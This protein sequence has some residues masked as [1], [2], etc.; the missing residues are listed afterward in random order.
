[1]KTET[2]KTVYFAHKF[3]PDKNP[4]GRKDAVLWGF[5]PSLHVCRLAYGKDRTYHKVEVT[6]FEGPVDLAAYWAWQCNEDNKFK[7]VHY[8][9]GMVQMC[10]PYDLASYE[11]KGLGKQVPVTVTIVETFPPGSESK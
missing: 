9:K 4:R 11:E 10:F 8:F 2:M 7:H 1:M 5:Y 3:D 6:S